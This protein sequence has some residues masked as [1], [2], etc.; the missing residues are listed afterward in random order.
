M[1]ILTSGWSTSGVLSS[2]FDGRC[3]T[4]LGKLWFESQ[5]RW[6]DISERSY[7][8]TSFTDEIYSSWWLFT[9]NETYVEVFINFNGCYSLCPHRSWEFSSHFFYLV[10]YFPHPIC[11]T[12]S[13]RFTP[14]WDLDSCLGPRLKGPSF[15]FFPI[16]LLQGHRY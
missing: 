10:Y 13:N 14:C 16:I 12:C 2:V 1:L 4:R 9:R 6:H 8:N 11:Q 15:S 5:G 7:T 3:I